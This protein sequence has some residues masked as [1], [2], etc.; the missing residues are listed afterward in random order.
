MEYGVQV[1][2]IVVAVNKVDVM[3]GK[4]AYKYDDR[5]HAKWFQSMFSHTCR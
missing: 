4:Y 3:V 1:G 5:R 2:G